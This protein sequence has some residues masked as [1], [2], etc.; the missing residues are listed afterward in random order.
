M[1]ANASE[2]NT[3]KISWLELK[4]ED[5]LR[6]A[7][8]S[9]VYRQTHVH[10]NRQLR[11]EHGVARVPGDGSYSGLSEHDGQR[12]GVDS[13]GE[14]GIPE[15][16]TVRT[17]GGTR[18]DAWRCSRNVT[19]LPAGKNPRGPLDLVAVGGD[20]CGQLCWDCHAPVCH[21]QRR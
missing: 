9:G 17:G 2:I 13:R 14:P 3:K 6:L 19:R 7:G 12:W 4:C 10:R 15:V 1:S 5:S 21:S 18:A 16:G 11:S 20:R 8:D